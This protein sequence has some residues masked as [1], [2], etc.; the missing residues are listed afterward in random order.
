MLTSRVRAVE[1]GIQ[2][3]VAEL[4]HLLHIVGQQVVNKLLQRALYH[5][6]HKQN[7]ILAAVLRIRISLTDPDLKNFVMDPDP[8]QTLIRIRR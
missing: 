5:T 1:V 8:G 2:P 6:P 3:L 7:A 4:L